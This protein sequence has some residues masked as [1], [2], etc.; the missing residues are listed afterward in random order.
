LAARYGFL[1]AFP[2]ALSA[3]KALWKIALK[4]EFIFALFS[5]EAV[6]N[7]FANN[8]YSLF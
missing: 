7:P 1:N 2:G 3:E 5:L 4:E 8:S 6:K